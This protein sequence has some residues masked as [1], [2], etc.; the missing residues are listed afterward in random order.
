ML[1]E[2]FD[3]QE[4][5]FSIEPLWNRLDDDLSTEHESSDRSVYRSYKDQLCLGMAMSFS[6]RQKQTGE[7]DAFL[8]HFHHDMLHESAFK[9]LQHSGDWTIKYASLLCFTK[10]ENNENRKC[11]T[12]FEDCITVHAAYQMNSQAFSPG[13]RSVVC[14]WMSSFSLPIGG[15]ANAKCFREQN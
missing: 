9:S 12:S 13:R 5:P 6:Y 1:A 4:A 3:L 11:L 10:L 15:S 2:R 7:W 8:L 14:S